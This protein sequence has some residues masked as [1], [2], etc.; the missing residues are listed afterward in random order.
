MD[1]DGSGATEPIAEEVRGDASEDLRARGGPHPAE[2]EVPIIEVAF[3]EGMWWS[4]PQEMSAE[5][6]GFH[7]KG[8]DAAYTGAKHRLSQVWRKD[9]HGPLSLPLGW[10]GLRTTHPHCKLIKLVVATS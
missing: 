2:G 1:H 9:I 4:M 6:Y 10:H 8:Q 7:A 5:L 3:N